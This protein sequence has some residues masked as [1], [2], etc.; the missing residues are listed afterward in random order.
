MD[1]TAQKRGPGAKL[2]EALNVPARAAEK[3]FKP[4]FEKVMQSLVQKDDTIRSILLG[5]KYGKPMFDVKLDGKSAKDLLKDAKSYINRREYISAVSVLS[6]FHKKMQ[7]VANMVDALNFDVSKIHHQFLFGKKM[8]EKK[9]ME[10]ISDLEKRI[11][12]QEDEFVKRAGLVDSL[13]NLFTERGRALSAWEKRYEETVGP[14]REAV[15][16]QSENAQNL[17][18]EV[19][20]ILKNMANLRAARKVDAYVE[21]ARK[22]KALFNNYDLGAKGFRSFYNTKIKPH[23]EN[24]RK[25]ELEDAAKATVPEVVSPTGEVPQGPTGTVPGSP[26]P[27]AFKPV[28]GPGVTGE[29]LPGVA[30]QAQPPVTT[31]PMGVV[32]PPPRTPQIPS[33]PV[34]GQEPESKLDQVHKDIM[35]EMEE[36]QRGKTSA[37]RFLDSLEV[38]SN[39]TPVVLAAHISKYARSIQAQDPETALQLFKVAKSLRG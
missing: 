27:E 22:I 32:P 14:L 34:P 15:K 7:D 16:E 33:L 13:R 11:A 29:T 21:E 2:R 6:Q 1:K 38:Y 10:H 9:Y 28:P 35:R 19:L 23:I 30:P 17:L 39:E 5:K 20:G 12:A 26:L 36:K 31:K 4:E 3:F 24:Q 18:T 25:M 8:P 37:E